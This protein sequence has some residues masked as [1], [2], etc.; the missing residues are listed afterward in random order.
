MAARDPTIIG[1]TPAMREGS[2]LVEF[3]KRFPDRY[4]DVAIAEQHAVTFAAGSGRGGFEA[5]CCDLFD[6][7]AARLR[8][9]H[10]RRSVAEPAR[11]VCARSRRPRR[12]RR[13]D[14]PGK[15]RRLLPAL[16][17]EH[18]HHGAG[19]RERVPADVVY[20]DH[21]EGTVGR[22]LS[23]RHGTGRAAR[24]GN[25]GAAGR[26]GADA[27]RRP[28]RTGDPGVRHACWSRH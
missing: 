10:S 6:L 17:S 7:P 21:V 22:A 15:L 16:Y 27:P 14:P 11:G 8:S 5:C 19:G 1:V 20:G 12:Q 9:A 26:K 24:R 18:G 25:D 28:Q 13:C 2:G 23:A 4:F 3:S